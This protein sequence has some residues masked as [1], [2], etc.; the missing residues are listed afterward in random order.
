MQHDLKIMKPIYLL[1]IM[2]FSG[3]SDG[4]ESTWR[5][6]FNPCVGKIPWRR[7]TWQPT[8]VFLLGGFHGHRSLA[9]Y[10]P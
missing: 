5:P 7:R 8:P 4:K 6:G 1:Y 10:S 9:G 3:G 2:G